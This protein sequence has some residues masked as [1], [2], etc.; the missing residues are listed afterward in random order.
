MGNGDLLQA[1]RESCHHIRVSNVSLRHK[2]SNYMSSSVKFLFR[3]ISSPV[4]ISETN[5]I[6]LQLIDKLSILKL[7][8]NTLNSTSGGM[9]PYMQS[10]SSSPL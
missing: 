7:E 2:E 4:N 6:S 1:I 10:A 3:R 8:G 9:S 5:W